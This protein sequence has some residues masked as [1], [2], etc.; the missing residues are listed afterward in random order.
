MA[1]RALCSEDRKRNPNTMLTIVANGAPVDKPPDTIVRAWLDLDL[2]PRR[3]LRCPRM[4]DCSY[5]LGRTIAGDVERH[6]D[7]GRRLRC[8][9]VERQLSCN[10]PHRRARTALRSD[11]RSRVRLLNDLAPTEHTTLDAGR[12]LAFPSSDTRPTIDLIIRRDGGFRN[13]T[14]HASSEVAPVGHRPRSCLIFTDVQP[15]SH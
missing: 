15:V 2:E 14:I 7:D 8:P 4:E 11:R 9:S 6:L 5:P 13:V 10:A 3:K 1:A 12:M